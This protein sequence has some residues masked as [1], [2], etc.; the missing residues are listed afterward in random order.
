M[1]VQKFSQ[2]DSAADRDHVLDLLEEHLEQLSAL[3]FALEGRLADL[4]ESGKKKGDFGP[5]TEWR[6]AQV[7]CDMLSSTKVQT[8]IAAILRERK[9]AAEV[10]HG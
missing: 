7:M 8:D 6:L 10:A 3:S 4:C 2:Q 5:L 9:A 1:V